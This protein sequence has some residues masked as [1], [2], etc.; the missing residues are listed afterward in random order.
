MAYFPED[1]YYNPPEDERHIIKRCIQCGEDIREGDYYYDIDGEAWCEDC[2]KDC[3]REA[4][5]E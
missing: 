4:E 5:R 1:N 3:R 2:V